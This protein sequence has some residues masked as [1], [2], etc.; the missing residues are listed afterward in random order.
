MAENNLTQKIG[1]QTERATIR[2]STK[3]P[4]N[5]NFVC[6]YDVFVEGKFFAPDAGRSAMIN[7]V[8]TGGAIEKSFYDYGRFCFFLPSSVLPLFENVMNS[9][10]A[11]L[12]ITF[13]IEGGRPTRDQS[14][15]KF[16]VTFK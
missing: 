9:Q 1:A 4:A 5:N 8:K 15:V 12:E 10:T 16:S 14:D 7:F 13:V 3:F 6:S 2:V 11:K